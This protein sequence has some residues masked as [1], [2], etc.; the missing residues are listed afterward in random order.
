MSEIEAPE[1]SL[2]YQVRVSRRAKRLQIRVTTFGDIEVVLPQRMSPRHIQPFVSQHHD[3]IKRT[4][5]K[6][7]FHQSCQAVQAPGVPDL[8]ELKAVDE[9]FQLHYNWADHSRSTV[10]EQD[11]SLHVRAVDSRAAQNG[12]QRWLT[13]KAKQHLS[14]NLQQLGEELGLRYKRCT[15]RAQKTRWGSCSSTGT[16]S[17]NRALMFIE[18]EL[19]RYL[20]THELCHTMHMNHSPRYWQLVEHYQPDY[21]LFEK[22]LHQAS[23]QVPHWA[24]RK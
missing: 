17:L 16:I 5:A 9:H 19:V 6:F 7:L 14:D 24:R 10:R 8:I 4:R 21:R 11:R 18:P 13:R 12:L 23:L 22:R 2:E 3:W 1:S 15:I 20:M